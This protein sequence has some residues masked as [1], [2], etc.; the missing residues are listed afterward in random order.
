MEHTMKYNKKIQH[1]KAVLEAL[2]TV[3][4][5]YKHTVNFGR[6]PGGTIIVWIFADDYAEACQILKSLDVQHW[7]V[8]NSNGLPSCDATLH[9]DEQGD[10]LLHVVFYGNSSEANRSE[11]NRHKNDFPVKTGWLNGTCAMK[12]VPLHTKKR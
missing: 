4:S 9:L 7:S 2:H 12:H 11:A 10:V 6:T 3:C 5:D 8:G 1:I